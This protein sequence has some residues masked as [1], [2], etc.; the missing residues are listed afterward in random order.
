MNANRQVDTEA[1]TGE[2]C[3]VISSQN[4]L[5]KVVFRPP[6]VNSAIVSSSNE[7]ANANRNDDSRP[8]LRIGK[9]TRRSVAS[10]R[11]PML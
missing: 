1:M 10:G 2:I 4:C 8:A 7:V 11:A 5:G 3:I 9:V 6:D